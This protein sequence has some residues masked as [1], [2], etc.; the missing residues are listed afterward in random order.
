MLDR[1]TDGLHGV[2]RGMTQQQKVLKPKK[3]KKMTTISTWLSYRTQ[4]DQKSWLFIR[5]C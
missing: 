4:I 3:L 5:E 1:L 2:G